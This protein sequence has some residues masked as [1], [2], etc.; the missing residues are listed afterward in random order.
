M[1]H[2]MINGKYI[3]KFFNNGLNISQLAG[4]VEAAQRG[5]E[6]RD[7][8]VTR[9]CAAPPFLPQFPVRPLIAHCL[10]AKPA[11]L[12]RS[13]QRKYEDLKGHQ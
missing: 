1:I 13:S 12:G 11:P 4:V 7:L 10:I 8:C 3:A 9:H 5:F 6:G 2:H